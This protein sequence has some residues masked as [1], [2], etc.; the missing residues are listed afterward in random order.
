MIYRML[1]E[2]SCRFTHWT[3]WRISLEAIKQWQLDQMKI[4][5]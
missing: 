4:D 2:R 1:K 5:Y 3:D